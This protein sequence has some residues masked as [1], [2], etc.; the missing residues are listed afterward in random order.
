MKKIKLAVLF[1]GL[2]LMAER[3]S[4]SDY[5]GD[6]GTLVVTPLKTEISAYRWPGSVSVLTSEDIYDTGAKTVDEALSGLTGIS[7]DNLIGTTGRSTVDIRSTG[8]S[9]HLRNLVLVDGCRINRPDMGGVNWLEIP[10]SSVEQI[11]VVRGP[12]G[13]MYGS[14]AVGGVINIVTRKPGRE[15]DE[16]LTLDAVSESYGVLGQRLGYSRSDK[17]RGFFLSAE[18]FK[19]EGYR[20]R[21]AAGSE[22]V[23]VTYRE[24]TLPGR[25]TTQIK[26][27]ITDSSY[28][29]PG[30][31]TEEELKEDRQQA[32]YTDWSDW[33]NFSREDNDGDEAAERR[34]EISGAVKS[35]VASIG[36]MSLR[37]GY[38]RREERVDMASQPN[39]AN[40][41]MS[42]LF[43][44]PNFIIKSKNMPVKARVAVGAD[45]Y[46]NSL[47]VSL[48]SSDERDAELSNTTL[49]MP[50]Y[51]G[52]INYEIEPAQQ[53]IFS[54]GYR[55]EEAE[56]T[57]VQDSGNADGSR[58]HKGSSVKA[59]A[60]YM[61][62]PGLRNYISFGT[63]YRYPSAAEQVSY[64]GLGGDGFFADLN[65]E[66]GSSAETGFN[67]RFSRLAELDFSIYRMTIED[68]IN[69]DKDLKRN[70][71]IGETRRDGVEAGLLFI[72]AGGVSVRLGVSAGDTLF[73]KGENKGKKVPLVPDTE[74][75][76]AFT[77][78]IIP[79]IKLRGEL[80]YVGE[81]FSGGDYENSGRP[82]PPHSVVDVGCTL[83]IRRNTY[84]T[85]GVKNLF[86]EL[87]SFASWGGWYPAPERRYTVAVCTG[88]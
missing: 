44:S 61:P 23:S 50:V 85:A 65:S 75:S 72:P 36:E 55:Y 77:A 31:L 39:F 76:A 18:R 2:I 58:S 45:I 82:L 63:H 46:R 12:A 32:K 16:S 79:D 70:V 67:F 38:T 52:Y 34:W 69:W 26:A 83:T 41:D 62:L 51:G 10:L 53:V 6:L 27:S 59:G 15:P 71:N 81:R 22:S 40:R 43:F 48:F 9:A 25:M 19:E 78:G 5:M 28:E 47:D 7:A 42:A 33:P 66:E 13:V 54:A 20:N 3:G 49:D 87:Y 21:S 57:A 86:N 14:N 4:A 60:V 84:I 11:E 37:G 1:T 56:I 17:N 73:Q 8:E 30:S 88:F 68:M 74:Y 80:N 24:S 64:Q 29:M 35:P